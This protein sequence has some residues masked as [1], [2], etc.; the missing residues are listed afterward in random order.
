MTV[1]KDRTA[2]FI[3]TS[4]FLVFFL[5]AVSGGIYLPIWFLRRRQAFNSLQ[6]E[7]K[8]TKNI[9]VYT[10]VGFVIDILLGLYV[11]F[12]GG[13]AALSGGE[14]ETLVT[15]L[16]LTSNLLALA[17]LIP[18]I[19]QLFKAKKILADHYNGHLGKNETFSTLWTIL[20]LNA[21]LQHKINTLVAD[22]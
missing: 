17:L 10:T 11:G 8:L 19:G 20:L 2:G 3:K 12:L 21:Y 14:P 6:S 22:G 13:M 18:L 7:E 1:Q 5:T 4:P 15:W 9:F 16:D